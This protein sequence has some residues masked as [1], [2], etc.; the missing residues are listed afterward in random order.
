VLII[1]VIAHISVLLSSAQHIM[2]PVGGQGGF[3]A[4]AAER[5][6]QM[7]GAT[8]PSALLRNIKVFG[9]AC[10]AC[11]GGLLY[12]YNQG[13]FSGVLTMTSFKNGMLCCMF[14]KERGKLTMN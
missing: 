4:A 5:R 12:G 1:I 3:E 14:E 9:I 13:V 8:G 10:F 7:T 2:A 6:R 11:L